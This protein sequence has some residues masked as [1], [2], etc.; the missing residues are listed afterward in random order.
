MADTRRE[1]S[2]LQTLLADNTAGDIS[3]Q[4]ARDVLV[5]ES[6]S[7]VHP[8]SV[9]ASPPSTPVT[10][11]VWLPSDSFFALRYS[12]S[13]WVAFGP[14]LQFTDPTL[15]SFAW[16]NQGSATVATT[17]GGIYLQGSAAAGQDLK[18]RKK[19]APATPYTI[20]AA[21]LPHLTADFNTAGL[22][23]REASSGKLHVFAVY[24]DSATATNLIGLRSGKWTDATTF[25]A[26]YSTVSGIAVFSGPVVWL[27]IA[28]NGTNRI[29][30]L[31]N[32]GQNWRVFHT[33]GR[34]DFCTAD[35]VG[36]YV[37]AI[38]AT[39]PPAMTLLSWKEG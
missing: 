26:A 25:S 27:R 36:F 2:A 22:C 38:N 14:V 15:Q 31:S 24:V 9:F 10:G 29:C 11:D 21:F 6:P 4:D 33:I 13:A 23:F 12:G 7:L 35:E 37:N 30:S 34:T 39:Y 17:N 8:T 32:D 28:D 16:I 20:T 3:A 19:S 5:S 1:L 18:I